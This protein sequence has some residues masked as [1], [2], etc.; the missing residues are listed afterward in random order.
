MTRAINNNKKYMLQKK[1]IKNEW[2]FREP[3]FERML[4]CHFTQHYELYEN[5]NGESTPIKII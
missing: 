1:F 4:V 3:L 5:K 2:V